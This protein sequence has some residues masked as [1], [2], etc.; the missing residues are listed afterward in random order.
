M[1]ASWALENAIKEALEVGRRVH[2][3]VLP[4]AARTRLEKLKLIEQIPGECIS[5]DRLQALHS[6][7]AGLPV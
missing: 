3:V 6:A 4:G 5:E 7:V 1:T 2:L